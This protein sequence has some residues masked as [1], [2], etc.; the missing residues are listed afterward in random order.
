MIQ[1]DTQGVAASNEAGNIFNRES[2]ATGDAVTELGNI[3]P[4]IDGESDD[5][6]AGYST[7]EHVQIYNLRLGEVSDRPMV[8][9]NPSTISLH[10]RT[11]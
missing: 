6:L 7:N 9:V 10:V 11:R 1:V 3:Q 4:I 5:T 8:V 2:L